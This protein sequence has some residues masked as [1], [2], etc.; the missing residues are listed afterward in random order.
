ALG[1]PLDAEDVLDLLQDEDA[2]HGQHHQQAAEHEPETDP[3]PLPLAP[4][5]EARRSLG[6]VVVVRAPRRG[7]IVERRLVQLGLDR[8]RLGHVRI[9][10]PHRLQSA[11]F[12]AGNGST[13]GCLSRGGPRGGPGKNRPR[14]GPP[15]PLLRLARRVPPAA[16]P[17]APAAP[18]PPPPPTTTDTTSTD[19]TTT[20]PTT[21][22]PTPP[23][24]PPKKSRIAPGVTISG[25]HVGGLAYGPA[26]SAVSVVFRSPVELQ[27]GDKI[28]SISPWK[29]G[30][31]PFIGP[32]IS[33]ALQ[34][35]PGTAV[36]MVVHVRRAE[37]A[38]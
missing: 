27:L 33:R 11:G 15:T 34:A 10:V 12:A 29:L 19:T 37:V 38:A 32:A 9:L 3:R 1:W 16:P 14:K 8:C 2:D 4:A 13:A 5:L 30:A 25:I 7:R 36:K 28:L 17:R 20:T 26:Y 21:T 22:T 24:P 18:P 31:K 35:K 6:A 23:K